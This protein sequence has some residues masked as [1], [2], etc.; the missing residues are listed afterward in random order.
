MKRALLVPITLVALLAA[1]EGWLHTGGAALA[2][3]ELGSAP[4]TAIPSPERPRAAPLLVVG[5]ALSAGAGLRD[6]ER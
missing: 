6:D 5:S 1:A 2:D 4:A 3:G